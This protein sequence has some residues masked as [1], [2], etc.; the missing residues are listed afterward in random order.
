MLHVTQVFILRLKF[1]QGFGEMS[2][3]LGFLVRQKLG[4]GQQVSRVGQLGS[5]FIAYVLQFHDANLGQNQ[6]LAEEIELGG[7]LDRVILHRRE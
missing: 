6:L 2:G 3:F 7:R 5:K 1:G 4:V